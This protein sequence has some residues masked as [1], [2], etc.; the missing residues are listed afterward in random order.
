M[1]PAVRGPGRRILGAVG[2]RVAVFLGVVVLIVAAWWLF[3]VFSGVSHF[4]GKSPVDVWEY[5]FT[6][7]EADQQ[8]EQL[9]S[10][11]LAT[12][13]D[14]GIGYVAGLGGAV[15][16]AV[17][18]AVFPAL[19]VTFMPVAMVLRTFPL[20]AFTPLIVLAV[21][22]GPG[23]VAVVGFIVVFFAALVTVSF[24]ISN[25]PGDALEVITVFGGRRWARMLKVALPAAVPALFAA[26]RI[27]VPQAMAA[28]L[29]AEWL[30]TGNGA[31]SE[32]MSAAGTSQ[33]SALWTYAAVLILVSTVLYT[34]VTVLEE[35]VVERFRGTA[36]G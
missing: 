1:S 31:G 7:E 6:G 25:A 33:Y 12:L 8:R 35:I 19:A 15:A 22:R 28:A 9:I 13:A 36:R 4:V 3:L 5:L 14:A 26:A 21:G 23:G 30:I 29:I 2:G 27:A 17:V 32:L 16:V 24:G 10:A 20:L 34:A 18:F 11:M